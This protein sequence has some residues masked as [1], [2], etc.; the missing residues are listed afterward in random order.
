MNPEEIIKIVKKNGEHITHKDEIIFTFFKRLVEGKNPV[1]E[2]KDDF[3]E[4]KLFDINDFYVLRVIW[5]SRHDYLRSHEFYILPKD[6]IVNKD[7][8][9][10]VLKNIEAIIKQCEEKI[11]NIDETIKIE[12]PEY[13]GRKRVVYYKC[14]KCGRVGWDSPQGFK[15]YNKC[16]RCLE[17]FVKIT[18]DEFIKLLREEILKEQKTHITFWNFAKEIINTIF[19]EIYINR[20]TFEEDGIILIA[21]IPERGISELFDCRISLSI[22]RITISIG[23][24]RKFS[25][26]VLPLIRRIDYEV[27]KN[28]SK[29]KEVIEKISIH[30]DG[31]D[32]EKELEEMGFMKTDFGYEK[33]ILTSYY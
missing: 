26:K 22:N 4:Y 14:P 13:Y 16:I 23:F 9:S 2:T 10:E 7:I 33:V 15:R 24:S 19:D 21:R 27:W 20:Y 8:R 5:A 25:D 32:I 1:F 11:E 29:V 31:D 18:R 6:Y 3:Y 12:L 17:K 30:V 28:R